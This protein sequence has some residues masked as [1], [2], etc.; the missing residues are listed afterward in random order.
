[1]CHHLTI[2]AHTGDHRVV[3]QC[4][5]GIVHLDWDITTI[6][7]RLRDFLT[8]AQFVERWDAGNEPLLCEG[9]CQMTRGSHGAARL[10]I[11]Q[12]GLA[13]A[14]ADVA[15]FVALVQQAA[16]VLVAAATW[17]GAGR[18]AAL[19]CAMLAVDPHTLPKN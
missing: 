13:I 10:W 12:V 7:L 3:A 6:R 16:G 19:G 18:R 9:W 17:S 5:H 14:A 8:L 1:M 15:V 11:G 4:E 2:L